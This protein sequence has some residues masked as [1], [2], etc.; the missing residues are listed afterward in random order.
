MLQAKLLEEWEE[1]KVEWEKA[2]KASQKSVKWKLEGQQP[3]NE[4]LLFL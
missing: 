2:E 1:L 3:V 4:R